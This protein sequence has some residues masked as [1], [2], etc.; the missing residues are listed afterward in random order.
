MTPT[1]KDMRSRHVSVWIE[2]PPDAVYVFASDPGEW[3]RWAAG[4]AQG[5]L[6]LTAE[7]WIADSPM[8]IVRVSFTPANTHGVLDHVVEL[9]SGERVYNPLRV[10][11]AGENESRCEVVFTVRQRAGM[12]DEQFDADVAAVEADLERLRALLER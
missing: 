8:G 11:P 7:G 2:A 6:R 10:V 9:P 1:L 5:G 12:T 4:L 3:P